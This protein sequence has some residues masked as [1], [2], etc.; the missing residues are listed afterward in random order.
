MSPECNLSKEKFRMSKNPLLLTLM[1]LLELALLAALAYWGWTQ[2]EGILRVLL[3]ISLPVGAAVL[4]GVF[5][6]PG[7][8]GNA[9]VAVRGLVRLA[10]ELGLFALAVILLLAANQTNAA[11][12]FGGLVI[13]EYGLSYD[14]IYR[15]VTEK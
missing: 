1:F 9:P 4:W 7:E 10:I 5:R 15:F 2:H 3:A 13:L 12:I 11:I 6:V 14:R 8:P